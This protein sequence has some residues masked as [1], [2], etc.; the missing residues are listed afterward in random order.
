MPWWL[1]SRTYQWVSDLCS[2]TLRVSSVALSSAP[3]YDAI[4]TSAAQPTECLH[5]RTLLGCTSTSHVLLLSQRGRPCDVAAL[6]VI[7]TGQLHPHDSSSSSSGSMGTAATPPTSMSRSSTHGEDVTAEVTA[8]APGELL[9]AAGVY[10]GARRNSGTRSTSDR[11]SLASTDS[12]SSALGTSNVADTKQQQGQEQQHPGPNIFYQTLLEQQQQRRREEQ[13]RAQET[14]RQEQQRLDEEQQQQWNRQHPG[15]NRYF[16]KPATG[17]LP[18]VCHSLLTSVNL[19]H[20]RRLLRLV[21]Q[22][23]S[24]TWQAT[25]VS[26]RVCSAVVCLIGKRWFYVAC[27]TLHQ[28][29]CCSCCNC[30]W[31]GEQ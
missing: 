29:S 17:R 7:F 5:M 3:L 31:C 28:N 1:L 20:H 23:P 11:D 15:P 14:R 19:S 2:G 16:V 6:C 26:Q 22:M 27:Y 9:A 21:A 18:Q 24:H 13:R 12:L 4:I 25:D 30:R 10:S 8:A